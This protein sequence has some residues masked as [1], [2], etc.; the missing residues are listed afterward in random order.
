MSS[1]GSISRLWEEV[2]AAD[3]AAAQSLWERYCDQLHRLARHKV[4]HISRRVIDEEDIALSAFKSLCM[5]ARKGR[6]PEA[7]DRGSLWGLL[8]FI[9]AQKVADWKAYERR[10]KRGGG[11][12]RGNSALEG[13]SSADG[14][15]GFDQIISRQPGPATLNRWAEEYERL[16]DQLGDKKLR[17]IAEL[18]VQGHTVA[19]IANRLGVAERTIFRKLDLIRQCWGVE[20]AP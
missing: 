10:K 2:K 20:A 8:V 6:F 12:V 13:K 4:R 1:P 17:E 7:N 3:E 15:R 5:G 9:T 14:A 11:K 19:E 18:S 16:L